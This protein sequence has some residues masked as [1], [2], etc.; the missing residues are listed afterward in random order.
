M[1]IQGC[2][3]GETIRVKTVRMFGS[4]ISPFCYSAGEHQL[5]QF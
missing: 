1:Q 4:A 3:A 2:R 5:K